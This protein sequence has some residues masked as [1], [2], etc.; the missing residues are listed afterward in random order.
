MSNLELSH[1]LAKSKLLLSYLISALIN[2]HNFVYDRLRMS[3]TFKIEPSSKI[4]IIDNGD[5][6]TYQEIATLIDRPHYLELVSQIREETDIYFGGDPPDEDMKY[7]FFDIVGSSASDCTIDLSKFQRINEFQELLPKE[8]D[9]IQ[10]F[11]KDSDSPLQ[12]QTEAVLTCFEFGRPYYFIP[13]IIQSLLYDA[14]NAD[15]LKRTRAVVE[16]YYYREYRFDEVMLP[17]LSIEISQHSTITE[18]KQAL[19][20]SK[21]V[22]ATDPRFKFFN[23]KQDHCNN[24]RAYRHWYWDYL[25]CKSYAEV[26]NRWMDRPNANIN[27]LGADDNTILKGIK[28]YRRLLE[29]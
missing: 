27:N 29:L 5:T 20:E 8:F 7:L 23:K 1:T 22:F 11:C 19:Q 2:S 12:I 3:K 28:T 15:Y 6:N 4:E 26:S 9:N 13:I 25:S 21:R 24:I 17:K 14:V 16:D 18:V 10:T